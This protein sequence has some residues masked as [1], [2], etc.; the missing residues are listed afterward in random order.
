MNGRA[1]RWLWMTGLMVGHFGCARPQ[2]PTQDQLA[3][4][5]IF[6]LPGVEKGA[7][8]FIETK[9]GLHDAKVD[10]A[11]DIIEW[12]D[13]LDIL[14]NLTNLSRNREKAQRIARRIADYHQQYSDAPAILLGF[15]AGGGMA[16]FVAEALPNDLVLDRIIIAGAAISPNYDLTSAIAHSRRPVVNFYSRADWFML[17]WGTRVF[18]TMDRAHTESAGVAGFLDD[19]GNLLSDPRLVQIPWTPDQWRVGHRGDHTGWLARGWARV[20]LAPE[21]EGSLRPIQLPAP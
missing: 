19:R 20:M 15:S 4:G 16:L 5:C 6:L 2:M 7:W 17:D 10:M 12:G 14:G 8:Q 3:R 11:V 1:A 9:K 13:S 18:G 21:I